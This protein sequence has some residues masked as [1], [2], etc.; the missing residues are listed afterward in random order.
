MSNPSMN[1]LTALV[2]RVLHG[3]ADVRRVYR[4]S[5]GG[6][7]AAPQAHGKRGTKCTPCAAQAYVENA[8]KDAQQRLRGG[9]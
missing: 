2:Q 9:G 7:A 6:P 4:A 1:P 8:R 5:D 3:A